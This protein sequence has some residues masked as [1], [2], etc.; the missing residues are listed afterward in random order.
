MLWDKIIA[1]VFGII[2]KAIPDPTAKA[3]AKMRLLEM[4]HEDGLAELKAEVDL[5]MAQ[6]QINIAEANKSDPFAS[7][8]RPFI[9]WICGI[10]LGY[11]YLV[12]P[13]LPWLVTVSGGISAPLPSLAV[14]EL[15]PLVFG[16]LGLGAFRSYEKV[17]GAA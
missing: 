4:D 9:G 14:G 5:A 3:E 13:L 10:S 2:D 12:A 11:N 7:G 1:S 16:M 6:T 17:R 8:W 15:M